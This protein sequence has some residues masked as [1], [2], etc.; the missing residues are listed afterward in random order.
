VTRSV[1]RLLASALA[2]ALV[3]SAFA[4]SSAAAPSDPTP[5]YA[6][7]YIWY[8]VSSWKR[9]KIDYPALGRYSSD[10]VSFMRRHVELA[11][12]SGINGFLVSWKSTPVLDRRLAML[13]EVARRAHFKLGIVYQGLDFERR[14]L[15]AAKVGHD[16]DLLA[17]RY[18]TSAVFDGFGKPVVAWSG[19][20][21]F[22]PKQIEHVRD[23][24]DGRLL[25]LGTEK[26]AADYEAKAPLFDGDL[27][28]WSSVNPVKNPNYGAKLTAMGQ[29]AH[30][31]GG[32]WFAPA[33]PGF[34]ARRVGGTSVV[35][36]RDG[37]T[38]RRE[39]D[40]AQQS[41]PDA[42][43]LISWNEFSENTHVEPSQRYGRQALQTLA[44]VRGT[45]LT[46]VDDLDSSAPPQQKSWG[47]P[48]LV[49]VLGFVI[50]LVPGLILLRRRAR[51]TI[52]D[53]P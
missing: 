26:N 46:A 42:I 19:T 38:L 16:L 14:P 48:A 45:H 2:A 33:A 47:P 18:G 43:G 11:K 31:R 21:R 10:E 36:R 12:Q 6:H 8:S 27:Y 23:V 53:V 9:A 22:T 24:V 25:L 28:Y 4:S 5:V 29:A 37:E 17:R 7:Y 34:D 44:D 49:V 52:G 1:T 15:P 3:A 39:L 13:V 32:L 50:L 40:A 30:A 20:W 51:L 35:E 41:Q